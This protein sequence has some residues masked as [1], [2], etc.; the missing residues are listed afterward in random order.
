MES[1]PPRNVSQAIPFF[2]VSDMERSLRFY[3]DGLGFAIADRWIDDG[4]IRWCRLQREGAALM[5]QDFRRDGGK[6][7]APE[8]PLG[9]GVSVFFICHDALSIWREV[10]ARGVEASRPFVGNGMWVTSLRDPDGYRVEFE[11]LT[12]V[13][14]GT[15][16]DAG[17]AD[18]GDAKK[19]GLGGHTFRFAIPVLH[20]SSSEAAREFY[21]E[22]LGFHL[23]SV[24]R[25]DEGRPDPCYMAVGRGGVYLH[26]SS[27]PGD[28]VLGG[29]AYAAVKDV[30]ALH[31]ELVAR[32]VPIDT[33][34]VD[35]TW[36]TREMY[37]KDADRNCIRF[38]QERHG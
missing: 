12:S 8:G 26:L 9:Q 27:F 35:Q 14:E 23:E 15:A 1:R 28:G 4:S 5:L 6:R 13:P 17:A 37:V 21:C 34:P 3:V 29:V 30:D 20:V 31:A 33:G 7:W 19:H 25:L 2:A 38:V 32:G 22:R 10:T 18:S 16:F 11:S 24:N 36:G